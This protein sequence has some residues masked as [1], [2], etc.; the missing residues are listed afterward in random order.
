M[1]SSIFLEVYVEIV[2][3]HEK[4]SSGMSA[5][6]DFKK[7]LQVYCTTDYN[8]FSVKGVTYLLDF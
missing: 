5:E 7:L 6:R 4:N 2:H 3:T 1:T 8:I